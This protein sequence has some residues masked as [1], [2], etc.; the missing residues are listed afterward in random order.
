MAKTKTILTVRN[1]KVIEIDQDNKSS[2]NCNILIKKGSGLKWGAAPSK[3]RYINGKF[4]TR[5]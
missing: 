2:S 1:G 5:K 4:M 3:G